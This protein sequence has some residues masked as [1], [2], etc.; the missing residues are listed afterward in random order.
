MPKMKP[1]KQIERGD[2]KYQ[3][4]DKVACCKWFDR[5]SVTMQ[6]RNIF[7]MPPTSTVQL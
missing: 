7:G 3:F 5:R 2:Q 6:F 4:T 1:H